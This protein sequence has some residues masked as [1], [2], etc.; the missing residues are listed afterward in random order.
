MSNPT[1]ETERPLKEARHYTSN[2][3]TPVVR[4]HRRLITNFFKIAYPF[5]KFD[6]QRVPYSDQQLAALRKQH[7]ATASFFRHDEF[8]Y[9]SPQKGCPLSLGE[10]VRLPVALNGDLLEKM[11]R[12]LI[13][14]TFRKAFPDLLPEEFAPLRFPSRKY[15]HDPI[16]SLLPKELHGIIGFPR[17]NEVHVRSIVENG[18]LTQGLLI[19]SRHRWR[20]PISLH[21]LYADQFGLSGCTVVQAVPIPGLKDVLTPEES[22]IG[23]V[24][25]VEGQN[26]RVRTNGGVVSLPL[27]SLFLQRTREQIGKY[28]DFR[29]GAATATRVFERLREIEAGHVREGGNYGEIVRT[30]NWFSKQTYENDDGFTF[31]V[32]RDTTITH[33][34]I[35]LEPTKLVFDY[36]PGASNSRPFGGLDAHGPFDS[37]HFDKKTPHILA[38]FHRR[39][40]GAATQFLAQLIDGIPNSQYFKKGLRELFR[41]HEVNYVLKE[42]TESSAQS[43][44]QAID[45]AVREGGAK[46]FDIAVVECP[47]ASAEFPTSENPYYRAK[48]RLMS[49][50]IPVQCVRESH[51]RSSSLAFTL[52]PT[53]LQMYAKLGGVPWLLPGSQSVDAELVVGIGNTI[54]RPNLW[55]AAEQSR[56]VGLTTFFL[57]DGRYLMGQELKSVP[58]KEYF[59]ELLSSL[60]ESIDFVSKEYAWK[61]GK[62]VRLVFHVFKPLK[63]LEVEVVDQLVKRFSQF[64]ILYAFVTVSRV[65]PWIMYQ[66]AE[67][68]GERWRLDLCERGANLTIDEHSCL[69]QLK[70]EKDRSNKRHRP[71]YPVLMRIHEKSTYKD[72]P[73]IAQQVL[74]FSYLNWR[75]FFP[76]DLPAPIFYASLMAEMSARLQR[77][78]GW[79]PVLLDQHFRRK[80]WFL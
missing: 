47:N 25:F 18:R 74:N 30:A 67:Q 53:V 2:H 70:G 57:G 7:N 33:S 54:D 77:V 26:A 68:D 21:E 63:N 39:N 75:S 46:K 55:T 35:Q 45:E 41:L 13:F 38:V 28:L 20:F 80:A 42:I 3:L 73:F 23:E 24:M 52:G 60:Q 9:I 69:I 10:T 59:N 12:H 32:T 6:I 62:T 64:N 4:G 51:L 79:N 19:L 11:I 56:I 43:Y 1:L 36:G 37:S 17:V 27:K 8:T 58:Y 50:G 31:T 29:L 44:E 72:L 78:E 49:Y 71:P 40:H 15:E 14:R 22:V 16:R 34:G 65:H 76:T 5:E 48:S 66:A 61:T